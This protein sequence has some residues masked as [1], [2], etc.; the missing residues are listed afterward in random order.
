[1]LTTVYSAGIEGIDGYIVKVECSVVKRFPS[2]NV[3]GLPDNA[4]KE[5]KE[6]IRSSV[7]HSGF[8]F[9]DDEILINLAPADK[10]KTGTAFDLPILVGI[11]T[12]GGL[13]RAELEGSCFIGELSLSGEIRAVKGVLCM[14]SAAR[15]SGIKRV[16]VPKDNALEASVV[17]GIE[18]YG[19]SCVKE[20]VG[21]ITCEKCIEPTLFK[22]DEF[23]AGTYSS[24]PDFSDV[25]GQS[26]VKR[27][28]EIAAAGGHNILMIGPPGTGKSMLAKR[29]PGILPPLSFEEALETTKIYSSVGLIPPGKAIVTKRP[30]RSP[31]HTMSPVS[32]TGGGSVIKPGEVSLANNGVLFLDELPEFGKSVTETLR[33]PIEDR[34]I[35][36]TR[37]SGHLT[38]PSKFML[39]CAMNPCKCGYYGHPK[40]K[41]TCRPDEIR[42]YMSRISGPLLDRIDIQV[43]V[44]ALDFEDMARKGA[45]SESSLSVRQRVEAARAISEKRF[46]SEGKS[47]GCNAELDTVQIQK[48]CALDEE[49]KQ[50]MRMAYDKFGISARG[51]DRILRLARTIADLA[52]RQDVSASDIAEAVQYRTLDRKYKEI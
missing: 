22:R 34:R 11:L 32:L 36:I 27:A 37:A 20:L 16:F 40:I 14:C 21:H 42:K 3:V 18:V 35:T 26:F 25:K 33:Q 51:Y 13:I 15:N 52:G 49:G 6:R 10:K 8:R 12:S 44:P 45:P 43:E 50:I 46:R 4:V 38:F 47:G 23:L 5:S 48:Y 19:V 7:E 41:C 39:V 24:V 1:M 30:F 9:P 28:L 31:H 17:D 2:Y 29:L